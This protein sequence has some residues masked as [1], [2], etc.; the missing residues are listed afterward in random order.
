[1][2][3]MLSLIAVGQTVR[4]YVQGSLGNI[5]SLVSRLSIPTDRDRSATYHFSIKLVPF[6]S[7]PTISVVTRKFFLLL[8][9]TLLRGLPLDFTMLCKK[10]ERRPSYMVKN[11]TMCTTVI[12]T[13]YQHALDWQVEIKIVLS[14]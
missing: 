4:E 12:S 7:Y 10:V 6:P 9:N 2:V 5:G 8:C 14:A 11:L 1:M 3:S 13:K